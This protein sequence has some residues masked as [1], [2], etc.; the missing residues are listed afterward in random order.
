MRTQLVAVGT[1]YHSI[2]KQ[3]QVLID[4]LGTFAQFIHNFREKAIQDSMETRERQIKARQELDSYGS[5]LGQLEERKLK[6]YAKSVKTPGKHVDFSNPMEKE[7]EVC[8]IRFHEAKAKYTQLSTQ[9]ID[10]AGILQMKLAV[11]FSLQLQMLKKAYESYY[12]FNS[13]AMIDKGVPEER[14]E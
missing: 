6:A 2:C 11:D 5:K 12:N 7:L 1:T 8:R 9:V 13:G 14:E 10:K 4:A 3:R